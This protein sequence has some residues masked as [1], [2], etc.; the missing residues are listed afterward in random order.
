MQ[1]VPLGCRLHNQLSLPFHN[2]T[3]QTIFYMSNAG[4]C[5]TPTL[6]YTIQ[7]TFNNF[8]NNSSTTSEITCDLFLCK[9]LYPCSREMCFSINFCRCYY[10]QFSIITEET[11][12]ITAVFHKYTNAENAAFTSL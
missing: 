11:R 10:Q 5:F 1:A 9:G 2:V 6:Q 3:R 4:H 7:Q 12:K 8:S